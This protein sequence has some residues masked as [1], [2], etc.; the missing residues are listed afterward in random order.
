[1]PVLGYLIS[2]HFLTQMR[3]QELKET[4]DIQA[5]PTVILFVDGRVFERWVMKYDINDYR[6]GIDE[7]LAK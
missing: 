2:C 5:F 4:Y 6:R 3:S 7:A 1:M